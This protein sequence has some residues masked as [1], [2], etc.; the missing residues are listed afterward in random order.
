[1]F[2]GVVAMEKVLINLSSTTIIYVVFYSE[3]YTVKPA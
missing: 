1:M 3:G 2:V